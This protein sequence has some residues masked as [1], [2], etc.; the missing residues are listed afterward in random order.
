MPRKIEISHKTI[1]FTVF[2]LIGVW[3][4]F[5]I[6][7]I[8]LQLFVALLIAITLNPLVVR[9]SRFKIPKGISVLL[10][11]V[12][13]FGILGFLLASIVPVLVEQSAN[14]TNSLPVYLKGI[15]IPSFISES[16]ASELA[17]Q[18][19]K[20]PSQTLKVGISVFSNILNVLA[21][22][23]FA[24]Y[25]LLERERLDDELATLL[26][27]KQSDRLAR[28]IDQLEKKLGGWARGQMIL[29][30]AVGFASYFGLLILGIPFALSLALLAGFLEIVPILGPILAAVPAAVVGFGI[31]PVMGI[32]VIALAFLIQQLESYVLV[33]KVMERSVGISPIFV[34]FSLAVGFKMAGIVGALLSVPVAITLQVI[35]KEYLTSN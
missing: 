33:P 5:F 35:T 26:G 25:L 32:A 1:I 19:S 7:D 12:L 23:I 18:V 29:M 24:F 9:L 31:S 16:V 27:G 17:F 28:L 2:F 13:V 30:L 34:L 20:L 21:V 8:I 6:K 4:V 14:F 3:F 22:L 11:Y 15:E 10:V